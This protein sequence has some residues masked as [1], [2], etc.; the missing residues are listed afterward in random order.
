M[1]ISSM[2]KDALKESMALKGS[3]KNF[4]LRDTINLFCCE[5]ITR[6]DRVEVCLLHYLEC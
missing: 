3:H 1:G 4:I 2:E 5:R 6:N